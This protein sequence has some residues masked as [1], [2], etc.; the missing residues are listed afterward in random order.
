MPVKLMSPLQVA[1]S[2]L[3]NF[4]PLDL[5]STLDICYY[6]GEQNDDIIFKQVATTPD[7]LLNQIYGGYHPR[8]VQI[9]FWGGPPKRGCWHTGTFHS[10]LIDRVARIIVEYGLQTAKRALKYGIK[11]AKG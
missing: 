1:A 10:Y 8:A 7:K 5:H 6:L 11:S 3:R 4:E 9:R 2:L